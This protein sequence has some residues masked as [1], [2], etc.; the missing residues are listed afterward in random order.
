MESLTETI[1]VNDADPINLPVYTTRYGVVI[2]HAPQ[3]GQSLSLRW[4][5]EQSS[6]IIRAITGLNAAANWTDFR[7]AL[8]DW[9]GF[10]AEFLYADTQDDIGMQLAGWIPNRSIPHI[11][12][13]PELGWLSLTPFNQL[14]SRHDPETRLIVAA[15]QSPFSSSQTAAC[16]QD[17][18]AE[19]IK[20]LLQNTHQHNPDSFA[21]LQADTYNRFAACLMPLIQAIQFVQSE[22]IDEETYLRWLDYQQWL[23]GWDFRN[24]VDS[25]Y[26][27]LFSIFW[28]ELVNQVFDDEEIAEVEGGVAER[29]MIFWLLEQP[30]HPWWDNTSTPDITEDRDTSL[31]NAFTSAIETAEDQYGSLRERWQWG[32]LHT[33]A[34]LSMPLGESSVAAI[35]E[36]LNRGDMAVGGGEDTLNNTRWTTARAKRYEVTALSAF[37]M[38]IDL[39]DF[40]GSRSILSTGQSGHPASTHYDDMIELWRGVGYRDMLWEFGTISESADSTLRLQP[41]PSVLG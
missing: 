25:P 16:G 6:D 2:S 28:V 7:R 8:Q 14:P 13:S 36:L 12:P 32:S 17:S 24:E 34:F 3:Q 31:R 15:N 37:R 29:E 21:L 33:A 4:S 18:R 40:E 9:G 23:A 1:N 19:R 22:D 11:L 30:D 41:L 39:S 10:P 38:I 35:D 27:V 5:G 20:D 26:P